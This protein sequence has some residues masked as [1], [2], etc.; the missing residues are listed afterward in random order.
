MQHRR[1]LRSDPFTS[2][3]SFAAFS[4]VHVR[5]FGVRGSVAS[6][7]DDTRRYGGNTSCVSVQVGEQQIVFDAGTGIRPLGEALTRSG[8]AGRVHLFLSHL[9]WDHIQGFPFFA[10]AYI[11]GHRIDIHRVR[12]SNDGPGVREVFADQMRAPTFPVG[13]DVMRADLR[14][15]DLT[16]GQEVLVGRALVRNVLVDHPNGCAAYRVDAGG[17]SIVYATDLEHGPTP[18]PA[19]VELARG[20]DLLIY[21]AMYTPEEYDGRAGPSRRGW[22]HSTYDAGAAL[23]EAAGARHLCLFHHD[24]GHDDAFLDRLG[25]RAR[26][27]F[28]NSLVAAEGLELRL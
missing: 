4:P 2:A 14:F 27:R 15:E 28:P 6:A 20:A 24:P 19:L 22:G 1:D 11:P 18:D 5:F 25:E 16:P 9:H 8:D 23:A 10:P 7:G 26:A 12:P 17:R 21:D 13:L 3:G